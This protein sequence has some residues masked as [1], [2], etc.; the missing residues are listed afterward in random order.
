MF[1][2]AR[3][4]RCL[5]M[6]MM[7]IPAIFL[8]AGIAGA[9]S[10]GGAKGWVATDTYRVLNFAVLAVALFFILRK[11]VS[12]MLKSRIEGIRDQLS[13][14]EEKKKE[15]EKQLAEYE[16]KLA[17]LNQEAEKV[18]AEYIRQG[19]EAK[20]RI[21]SEAENA[22]QRLEEQARRNI[23]H[24]FEQ[25]KI[26]LQADIMDKALEKAEEIIKEKITLEDQDRLVAEYLKKVVES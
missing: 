10:G 25:A 22:A 5:V 18:I 4:S 2:E 15:A 13:D 6:V 14:L 7:L 17:H 1:S 23:E 16:E 12:K 21:L 24:E 11:P 8:C 26:N 19:T 3:R 20:N 9:A